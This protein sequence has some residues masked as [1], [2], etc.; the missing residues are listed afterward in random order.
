MIRKT[1]LSQAAGLRVN[2]RGFTNVESWV[3]ELVEQ[4]TCLSLEL[5]GSSNTG[6]HSQNHKGLQGVSWRCLLSYIKLVNMTYTVLLG[7]NGANHQVLFRF[8]Q[9]LGYIHRA[10]LRYGGT[11]VMCLQFRHHMLQLGG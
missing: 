5:I 8:S 10:L 3:L 6:C 11:E 2:C 1:L 7:N 9:H 4:V